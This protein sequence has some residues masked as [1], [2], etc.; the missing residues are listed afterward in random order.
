M[1]LLTRFAMAGEGGFRSVWTSA[2]GR[3]E[4]IEV[5]LGG[6]A[7]LDNGVGIWG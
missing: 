6:P 1:R 4:W 5:D 2:S 7:S 3:D